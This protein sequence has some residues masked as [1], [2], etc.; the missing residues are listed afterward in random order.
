[1][2]TTTASKRVSTKVHVSR[3]PILTVA[4]CAGLL[5]CTRSPEQRAGTANARVHHYS[6]DSSVR[7]STVRGSVSAPV[8][9]KF[10]VIAAITADRI[11]LDQ[12][13]SS[14]L[15]ERSKVEGAEGGKQPTVWRSAAVPD[16]I[17][18]ASSV[19]GAGTSAT[20]VGGTEWRLE[21]RGGLAIRDEGA[22]L[23]WNARI[24]G[25]GSIEDD[26]RSVGG[27][28][29]ASLEFAQRNAAIGGFL[30]VGSD[31]IFTSDDIGMPPKNSQRRFM[32]LSIGQLLSPTMHLSAGATV[33]YQSG[34]LSSPYRSVVIDDVVVPEVVPDMRSRLSLFGQ[35]AWYLG[36]DTAVHTRLGVYLDDWG[37]RAVIPQIALRRKLNQKLF[38]TLDY[39]YY[40]Q[41]ASEFYAPTYTQVQRYV[42]S[43]ARLGQILEQN[44]GLALEWRR[45]AG[46]SFLTRYSVAALVYE[47][48]EVAP[49]LSHIISFGVQVRSE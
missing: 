2:R 42:S 25:W 46:M 4:V 9:E 49:L 21:G 29:S 13:A 47:Q 27:V 11:A 41:G 20:P 24:E 18:A 31:S 48:V 35:L 30:G 15:Q 36:Y 22:S 12:D 33:T 34:F 14:S 43:D 17:S 16:V 5:G 1:M 37:T 3:A 10:D 8:S 44:F 26:Y 32:G 19:A 28:V 40:G 6:D 38:A 23:P 7:V 45:F 39:R